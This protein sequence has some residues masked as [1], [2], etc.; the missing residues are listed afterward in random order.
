MRDE[1]A[2]I[3]VA[4]FV[5]FHEPLRVGLNVGLAGL[6]CEALFTAEPSGIL[7]PILT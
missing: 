5:P 2:R 7:S 3:D 6:D 4:G 1:E